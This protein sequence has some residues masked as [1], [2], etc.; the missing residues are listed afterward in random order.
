MPALTFNLEKRGTG[1]LGRAGVITTPHGDIHT[2][3]FSPV[4]T[5]ASVSN[6]GREVFRI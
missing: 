2:P 3:A 6:P 5:K 1:T 4:G